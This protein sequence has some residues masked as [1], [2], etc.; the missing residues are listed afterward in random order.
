MNVRAMRFERRSSLPLG[1]ACLL[2]NGVRETLAAVFGV[3]VSLRLLEPIVPEANA[4]ASIA[5]DALLLRMRGP[6]A[7]AA[8]VLRPRDALALAAAAFGE[9][10]GELRALSAV[11]HEVVMRAL[12]ALSGTLAG[13]CGRELAAPEPILDIR[14]YTTYLELLVSAPAAFGLGVALARDPA[15]RGGPGLRIEDLLDVELEVGVQFAAGTISG[16][17]FLDLRP[18]ANVPMKTRMGERALLVA[19]G[20]VLARGECGALGERNAMIVGATP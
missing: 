6:V 16:G 11:E 20:T 7:E 1:A 8:F 19:G 5:E 17:R 15:P 10:P 9:E 12:R 4:W 14:G 18:G 13:I 2:A 3:P